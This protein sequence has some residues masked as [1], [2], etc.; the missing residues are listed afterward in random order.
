[1]ELKQLNGVVKSPQDITIK[2]ELWFSNEYQEKKEAYLNSTFGFRNFLVRLNNQIVYSVFKKANANG[3]IVGKENYLYEESYINAFTGKDFLGE[4]SIKN[5]INSLQF[6]SDT[7]KKLDKQLIVVFAAGKASYYP[8]FI[9]DKYLL[10]KHDKTNYKCFAEYA[11][12]TNLNIIDFNKWFVENRY[13]SKY[14]LYPQHGIHWSTYGTVLAADSL[15]RKIEQLRNIDSPNLT[16]TGVNM[17]QAHDVDYDIGDGM[18]LIYKLKSFEV[19]YPKM[20]M[21]VS[22]NKTK[23]KVLVISDSFYWGMYNLGI[24][25]C[26][27][28]DHF[29]YYNKQVFP[30]SNVKETTTDQQDFTSVIANHDVIVLMATEATL[31]GIGWG[32][33]ERAEQYFEGNDFIKK[34]FNSPEYARR[35]REFVKYIKT[36]PKWMTDVEGRADEKNISVDSALV[37][38]AMWHVDNQPE[39]ANLVKN[40]RT[41]EY[42]REVKHFVEYIKTQPKWM[43]DAELRAKEKKVTLDSM[44]V[45]EAMWQ[46]DNSKK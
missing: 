42:F 24:A 29:W 15:V 39:T 36:Q 18:N 30:E 1:M 4:D 16:F 27:Q 10:K 2:R 7:L 25:N 28:N 11:K 34:K 45:I 33:I 21:V 40:E 3:V 38:E 44:L 20:N 12:I 13:K 31:R 9:P 43:R 22:E 8:E 14:P 5:I 32:F 17:E 35:V 19:A 6:I 26:F 37:L 41:P 23:P 46:V